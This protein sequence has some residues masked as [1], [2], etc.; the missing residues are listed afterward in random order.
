MHLDV[1][2]CL[3][4]SSYLPTDTELHLANGDIELHDKSGGHQ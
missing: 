3:I 4:E 2:I 1:P